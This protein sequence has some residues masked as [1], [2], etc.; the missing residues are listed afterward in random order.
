MWKM[1][2]FAKYVTIYFYIAKVSNTEAE[3]I[4]FL[5]K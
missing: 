5:P 1:M 3:E 4:T 2:G